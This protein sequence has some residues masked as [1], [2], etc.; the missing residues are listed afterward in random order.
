VALVRSATREAVAVEVWDWFDDVGAAFRGLAS[1]VLLLTQ[2]LRDEQPGIEW[3]VRG[4]FI[5][6]GTH[7]NRR[8]VTDLGGLFGARF[9]GSSL[10]WHAALRRQDIAM[11]AA[12]GMLWSHADGRLIAARLRPRR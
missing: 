9:G 5:I 7:R 8:L 2:L 3:R 1:K 10:R 4:L 12:D 6:R 11:P